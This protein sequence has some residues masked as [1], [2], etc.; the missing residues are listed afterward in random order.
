[1]GFPLLYFLTGLPK[2]V[3]ERA[4]QAPRHAPSSEHDLLPSIQWPK[5][6]ST[7]GWKGIYVA[8]SMG[9][10]KHGLH[11]FLGRNIAITL[12]LTLQPFAR[13]SRPCMGGTLLP[14][15][16]LRKAST[17][18]DQLVERDEILDDLKFNLPQAV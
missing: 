1:M 14:Q 3:F 6:L 9:N 2:C 18:E 10:R 12:P 16:N 13:H 4:F 17:L 7:S 5:R 15:C 11:G 8:L